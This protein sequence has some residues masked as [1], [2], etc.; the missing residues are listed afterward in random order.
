MP[1]RTAN[2][3]IPRPAQLSNA[4][5]RTHGGHSHE[6]ILAVVALHYPIAHPLHLLGGDP[7]A[8]Q[9]RQPLR[10]ARPAPHRTTCPAAPPTPLPFP[11]L[12][13]A[14]PALPTRPRSAAP[15]DEVKRLLAAQDRVEDA[16]RCHQEA[17]E[18]LERE[19][20]C[21]GERLPG[22]EPAV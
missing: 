13:S 2:S 5:V 12:L 4:A 14:S 21:V 1:P 22:S 17:R 16:M 18:R 10:C 8:E 9:G 3:P 11:F 20:K 6:Q 7:G 15:K 19:M